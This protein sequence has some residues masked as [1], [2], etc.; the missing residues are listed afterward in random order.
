MS[1][2]PD[3][4]QHFS[5][6][7]HRSLDSGIDHL[8]TSRDRKV[9]REPPQAVRQSLRSMPLPEAP[10]ELAD[11]VADLEELILPYSTGNTH[12]R[13]FGW[14]HGTGTTA[15]LVAQ[16]YEAAMNANCGGRDHAA[17][18]VERAVIE[19]CRQIFEFPDTASGILTA[20]TSQAT[21]IALAS[22]RCWKLGSAVR[23]TGIMGSPQLV[24]YAA[25]GVHSAS[26]KAMELLGLGSDHLRKIETNETGG[27][28]LSA[29]RSELIQDRQDGY[30]PFCVIGTAGTVNT[31]SFDDLAG[32]AKISQQEDLW[33][34]VDGAFGAWTK[35][36]P[37]PWPDLVRG[38]EQANS[39]AVDFHKWMY[40]QYDC[41]MVLIRD[42]DVHRSAFAER[43]D[44]LAPMN[45]GLGGGDPWF[46]DYG[47]DLSRGFKAL[48]IWMTLREH[49]TQRIGEMIAKNCRQ[50][51]YMRELSQKAAELE[52]L[53]PTVSNVCVFRYIGKDNNQ[54]DIDKLNSQI[55]IELQNSGDAVFSTTKINGKN[56][57]ARRHCQSPH[58]NERYRIVGPISDRNG[59]SFKR[60]VNFYN[61]RCLNPSNKKS[62]TYRIRRLVF[63]SLWDVSHIGRDG[64]SS[65]GTICNNSG[66]IEAR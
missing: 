55:A 44:Y 18:L 23:K 28:S 51:A 24:A 6:I 47:I 66:V 8:K 61:L 35:I 13:F 25:A 2:D 14:V 16:I 34:H 20:G 52:P 1:L 36:A 49:G 37:S 58:N 33:F 19:W 45:A 7:V 54:L 30:L 3:D 42:G 21:V 56:R 50:A 32:I 9:W 62:K 5:Q 57:F 27:M 40:V 64:I 29:L 59:K 39:I 11:V 17:I 43:P 60:V 26:S 15:G 12:P 22:A 31:G 53:S 65:C 46:C 4:W 63:S 38:I 48:K 41:G 10:T